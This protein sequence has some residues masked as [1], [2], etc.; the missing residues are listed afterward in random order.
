MYIQNRKLASRLP[1]HNLK[2]DVT[3]Y[4]TEAV[5][6]TVRR[7][8]DILVTVMYAPHLK[9]VIY[10]GCFTSRYLVLKRMQCVQV[11]SAWL[12]VHVSRDSL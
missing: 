3:F 4:H 2:K 5:S 8:K 12:Y 11:V 9:Y 10:T 7:I 1:V 6:Q